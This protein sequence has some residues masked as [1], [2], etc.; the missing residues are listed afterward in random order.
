MPLHTI[1]VLEETHA[2]YDWADW[3]ASRDALVS[4]GPTRYF[5]KEA[6]NAIVDGLHQALTEA[7]LAWDDTYTT[8]E[9]A[10]ITVA[11]GKL[12]AQKF[13]SVRHNIDWPAPL[14]W[15]WADRE[16]FR[17]YVGRVDF[18]GRATHGRECD[19]VY[20]E[21][22]I[23][24]VRKLNFLLEIMRGTAPVLATEAA[25]SVA[26]PVQAD[27]IAGKA[28]LVAARYL[29]G[30][31]TDANALVGKAAYVNADM[32][33]SVEINLDAQT[34]IGAAG[35]AEL[36]INLLVSA[37]GR[38][39]RS[40]IG[41]AQHRSSLRISAEGVS[42]PYK[43]FEAKT[44]IPCSVVVEAIAPEATET[45]SEACITVSTFAEPDNGSALELSARTR[46][47]TDVYAE[48]A[49]A[50]SR[51]TECLQKISTKIKATFPAN[52]AAA[53][54]SAS[55]KAGTRISCALDSAWYPP[56]WVD[57]GLWIRQAYS[58]TQN[59]N[60]EVVIL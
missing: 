10:K 48:S 44:M 54:V 50:G 41:E 55:H 31:K 29:T 56:M 14:G 38:S 4:G 28:A 60:G 39:M 27:V 49:M 3:Q 2:L 12:T 6:W 19:K 9:E 52:S 25:Y 40:V 13:N 18:N 46:V 5:A 53:L 36:G 59:D 35:S 30:V 47:R 57:G 42:N 7:G 22:I 8:A 37:A 1:P 43:E 15:A 16:D 34:G 17:G 20:P 24:L 45:G 23:E 21:Y 58:V 11:Y 51:A 33:M 26:S 32:A